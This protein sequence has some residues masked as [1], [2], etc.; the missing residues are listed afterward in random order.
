ML[1]LL[2]PRVL[3]LMLPGLLPP[4]L[5]VTSR[6]SRQAAAT[7]GP[8]GCQAERTRR[9]RPARTELETWGEPQ[10]TAGHAAGLRTGAWRPGHAYAAALGSDSG[11]ARWPAAAP[12]RRVASDQGS[13]LAACT[14]V[15]GWGGGRDQRLRRR[16]VGK[17]RE[18]KTFVAAVIRGVWL[19]YRLAQCARRWRQRRSGISPG[20][21]RGAAVFRCMANAVQQPRALGAEQQQAEHQRKGAAHA[22]QSTA[23]PGAARGSPDTAKGWA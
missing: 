16:A 19:V 13:L 4:V 9:Q 1:V 17:V 15:A 7:P 12:G 10:M 18:R 6:P 22:C 3:A 23:G 2:A 20:R 8:A 11:G 5:V 14:S 21:Q